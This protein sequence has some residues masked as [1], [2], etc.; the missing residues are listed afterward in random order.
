MD[1]DSIPPGANFRKILRGWVDE[2]EV[3]LAII[4]PGWVNATDPKTKGRRLDNPNDFVRIEI[5][6]ALARGIPVVPVLI[7]G[8]PLPDIDLLPDDLK[9][10]VDRQ[11][12]HLQFLTFEGDCE[13][14]IRK[15]GLRERPA[16]TAPTNPVMAL[17]PVASGDA[18]VVQGTKGRRQVRW[19]WIGAIAVAVPMLAYIGTYFPASRGPP[20]AD[21][22]ASQTAM[23]EQSRTDQAAKAETEAKRLADEAAKAESDRRQAEAEAATQRDPAL[24]VK[25]GSGENFIDRLADGKPCPRCPEMV[26]VPAGKFT[27]GSP[28]NEPGRRD[29]ETQISVAIGRPFAVGKFAVTFD[30]WDAC[31]V[32]SG[33]NGYRPNDQGWGRSNRP[34]IRVNWADANAFAEWLSRKTG[35]AYHLLS[36]T[37]RE[38]VMRAGTTTPFWWGSEITT[39]Q[40]N[41]NSNYTYNGGPKGEYRQRTVPV[42]SF[43]PNPWGLYNVHGNVWEWTEDCWNDSNQGNPGDGS[44]RTT[45]DCT[46][47]VVR[48]GS[49]GS[50]PQD[51]RAATRY[52]NSSDSRID[53]IGFRLARTLNP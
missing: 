2:C 28:R 40:A 11:A 42:D 46:Q 25:P 37:E 19:V 45:G 41:Y 21:P 31:V 15:L 17:P 13:R 38:Y 10:L 35:K 7:D 44:P 9:E 18:K 49:W 3:L 53:Y 50:L 32:D 20:A 29:G 30:Q 48:G 26:T 43:K 1:I 33:C 39:R 22:S 8:V 14:L 24:L 27:M 23:T 12:E 51:L 36:E 47:H 6:E 16:Q 4:G 52:W 34:V 5:G